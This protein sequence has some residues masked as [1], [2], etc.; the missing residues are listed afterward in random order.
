MAEAAH[1]AISDFQAARRRAD[2]AAVLAM[3]SGQSDH[4]LQYDEVRRRLKAV[5]SGRTTLEDVPLDAIVGSVGRYQDFNRSFLPLTN[6][7]RARWVGVKLAMTG[8]EGVPPIELYRI[9][10]AYFV[11]DGN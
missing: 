6:A 3:L 4:L 7:D 9:G 1:N 2:I 10:D 5:E 8:L 11:K